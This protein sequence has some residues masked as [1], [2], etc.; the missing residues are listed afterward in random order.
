PSFSAAPPPARGAAPAGVVAGVRTSVGRERERDRIRAAFDSASSGTGI[1]L[2]ISGDAG[3]GKTTI[4]EEFLAAIGA[5]PEGAWIARGRCSERPANA[6]AFAPVFECLDGLTRG[7]S[8]GDA[9][10]LMKEAAPTWLVQ[11]AP[12]REGVAGMSKEVSQERMRREF[13]RF[14]ATL[15]TISPVI[16]FLHDFHLADASTCSLLAYLGSR[17]K[18]SRI[19]IVA[20]YRP[21]ELCASHP[22]LPVRLSLER[23]GVCQE[24][25]LGLLNLKDIESYLAIRFPAHAF[26][27][28]FVSLVHE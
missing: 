18:D 23:S 13:V 4:G 12:G 21:S 25:P 17:M 8:G 20:T 15:S 14:F 10:R 27:P 7:E 28:E 24:I 1:M 26:S 11:I 6:D 9:E 3:M 19:L 2:A 16:V 5:D 22:F